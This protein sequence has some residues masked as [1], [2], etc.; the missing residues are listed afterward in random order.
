MTD[1]VKVK[2]KTEEDLNIEAEAIIVD[3]ALSGRLRALKYLCEN[4]IKREANLN[5]IGNIMRSTDN[6][7]IRDDAA[8][9]LH[10]LT[11]SAS[12]G[13]S[14]LLKKGFRY[15]PSVTTDGETK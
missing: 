7:D 4:G 8:M 11:S 5:R 13:G 3:S 2:P 6:E 14:T 9:I 10:K 15:D 12:S 1:E